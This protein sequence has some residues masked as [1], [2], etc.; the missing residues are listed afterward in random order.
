[1]QYLIVS[2]LASDIAYTGMTA[3]VYEFLLGYDE[4]IIFQH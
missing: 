1:M 4:N 3:I 2:Q